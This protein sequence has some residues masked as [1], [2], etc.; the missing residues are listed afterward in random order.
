MEKK[1]SFHPI[2]IL[3]FHAVLVFHTTTSWA[4]SRAAWAAGPC[5]CETL[6]L[7]LH[8]ALGP[9]IKEGDECVRVCPE[10]ST[11]VVRGLEQLSS[12]D[13]LR[14]LEFFSLEKTS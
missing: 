1:H 13:R 4:A 2:H 14:E 5:F 11:K 3:V 9:Q 6:P 8:P 7:V 12:E 10:E